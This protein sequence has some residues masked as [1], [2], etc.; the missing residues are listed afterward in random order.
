MRPLNPF[1]PTFG[2]TPPMLAGRDGL[3]RD[4]LDALATGPTHPSYTSLLLGRRGS[5]K[6]VALEALRSAAQEN[7]WL[8]ISEAAVTRGLLNRLAH[9]TAEHLNKILDELT[10][11]TTRDLAAAGIGVGPDYNPEADL[12]RRLTNVLRALASHLAATGAGLVVT[13]DELHAGEVG[14]LRMLGVTVQDVTRVEQLPLA[15]VGAGLPTLE[16]TLLADSSITF[17]QRCARYDVGFLEPPA[18]AAALAEPIRQRGGQMSSGAVDHAVNTSQGY[19]FL[20]QLVGFHAWEA[21][22][23]PTSEVT[24]ED[25]TS[26]AATALRQL[27]QL[28][29]APMW[30]DLPDGARRFLVAMAVDDGVSRMA[31]IAKRLGAS[32]GYASVYRQRLIKAGMVTPEGHGRLDFVLAAA[33]QWIRELDEYPLVCESLRLADGDPIGFARPTPATSPDR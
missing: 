22:E 18:A 10:A 28:V 3:L 19:P 30:K 9:D 27:G 26:G 31:A 5:G 17:L 20:I 33:R 4:V 8:T 16:D 1:A 24:L 32:S 14:E 25:V 15:F 6:T 2:A 13:V 11:E 23:D 29:V 12:S 21:A 7:G